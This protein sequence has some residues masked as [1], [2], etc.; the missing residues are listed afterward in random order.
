MKQRERERALPSYSVKLGDGH[1]LIHFRV[2]PW[3]RRRDI[4]ECV[5]VCG[6][7]SAVSEKTTHFAWKESVMFI[8][9]WNDRDDT[10][11]FNCAMIS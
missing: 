5:C 6:C 10:L 4:E 2:K 8:S 3:N 11:P 7:V 1:E 9:W